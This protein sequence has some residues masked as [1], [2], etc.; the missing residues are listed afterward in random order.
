MLFF[1]KN[2]DKSQQCMTCI[3]VLIL[4]LISF[5]QKLYVSCMSKNEKLSLK[6]RTI[7]MFDHAFNSYMK[8]AFPAD[9]IMPISCK[10]RYRG[11]TKS[12]GDIDEVLGNYSLT[13]VDTLDTLAILGKIDEFEIAVLNVLEH[14][15]FD[16]DIIISVFESNIRMLG[17]LLGGHISLI[18]LREN[19]YRTKFS[20]YN[21]ELLSK[22][23]DLGYRLLP[24]FNTSSGLPMSRVNLKYGLTNEILYN[25]K[26]QFTCTACAGTLL[27]EFS[28]LSRLTGDMIFEE[29]ALQALDVIWMNRNIQSNLVGTVINVVNSEWVIKDSNI[30][31][32]ID[33]YY[34]YL[35]KGYVLLGDEELLTRFN[36]HYE[37]LI[38]YNTLNSNDGM[39]IGDGAFLKTVS[40]HMPY[41]QSKSYIDS[42]LAFWPGLQVMKGDLKGAIK[43]H[44]TLNQ[45]VKRYDFIPEA[46]LFDHTAHWVG[47]LLRPEFLEST[48]YLYKATN[49]DYYLEIA[50]N[51]LNKVETHARV[52][53]G[54]AAISDVRTKSNEDRMDS[55]VLAELFKYFYLIFSEEKD[56]VFNLDEF[57]FTT[58][59]HLLPIKINDYLNKPNPTVNKLSAKAINWIDKSCPSLKHVFDIKDKDSIKNYRESVLKMNKK[60]CDKKS[61]STSSS[62]ISKSRKMPLR[63]SEFVA[64]HKEHMD[65]LNKMGI[66]LITMEDGRVQLVHKTTFAQTLEDAETGILFMTEML[67]LSKQQDFQLK[68]KLYVEDYRPMSVV[69]ISKPFNAK[70]EFLAG[71]AQFGYDF[72]KDFGIFGQLM[73]AEPID[74]C[75]E[76]RYPPTVNMVNKIIVANRGS[77]I[78]IE[79]A[80]MV[81]KAGALAL[82]IIDNTE[83]TAYSTSVL[84]SMSGDGKKDINIPSIFLFNKEGKELLWELRSDPNLLVYIGDNLKRPNE[85]NKMSGVELALNYNTKQL[86][87]VLYTENTSIP[88]KFIDYL[89]LLASNTEK[90][91]SKEDYAKL[92]SYYNI[93]N[94]TAHK[95]TNNEQDIDS[96]VESEDLENVLVF[97]ETIHLVYR[98]DNEQYLEIDLDPIISLDSQVKARHQLDNEKFAQQVFK[99][100]YKRF[101]ETTNFA[102]L[103]KKEA[104]S[105]AL[106]RYVAFTLNSDKPDF[107]PSEVDREMYIAFLKLIATELKSKD[108]REITII[109]RK[110]SKSNDNN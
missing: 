53:C 77:C 71:P 1:T 39:N 110:K 6:A 56:L 60:N 18:Y 43:M 63:A 84:F 30:G 103:D 47:H 48:Y 72:K 80:R 75:S 31:A 13:L 42:L 78:F 28:T 49:D 101:E 38:K 23:K 66:R 7:Q 83:G 25:E 35:F 70:K 100:L 51:L 29:K 67:E 98:D 12:R 109:T 33:S 68:S 27:L 14:V 87:K 15:D 17:G 32:G 2:N 102:Q 22:A 94:P 81:Q 90:T 58:E 92:E 26:D 82:I 106:E 5:D 11:V 54:Y 89:K 74:A 73:L 52:Q 104:Y 9:E 21:N 97:D 85:P 36:I 40:M 20:W 93:F 55:F 76:L 8:Y 59:A 79:K 99:I 41:R 88:N 62:T 95:T 10:G 4:S 50:K 44:E 61:D 3:F 65:I 107:K 105:K 108:D 96:E 37:S 34:E 45:I 91:C 46:V 57:I 69:L 16:H 19:G 24:A 64:G 86:I